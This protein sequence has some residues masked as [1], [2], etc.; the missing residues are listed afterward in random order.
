MLSVF[1]A[2]QCKASHEH[3]SDV[4]RTLRSI[5]ARCVLSIPMR[6]KKKVYSTAMTVESVGSEKTALFTVPTVDAVSTSL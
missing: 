1:D 2:T 3:A 6:P 4:T 5:S